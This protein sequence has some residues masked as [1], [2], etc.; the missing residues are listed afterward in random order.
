MPLQAHSRVRGKAAGLVAAAAYRLAVTD[1]AAFDSVRDA[2][3]AMYL[4]GTLC[5]ML[6]AVLLEGVLLE[7]VQA[8]AAP[9]WPP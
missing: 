5:T 6:P 4:C 9:G 2:F 8:Q 3:P 7:V 1:V